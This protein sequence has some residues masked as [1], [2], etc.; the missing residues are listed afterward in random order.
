MLFSVAGRVIFLEGLYGAPL[1][2]LGVPKG[3][4]PRFR[5]NSS[6]GS[7]DLSEFKVIG[8]TS[9]SDTQAHCLPFALCRGAGLWC[10]RCDV[11]LDKRTSLSPCIEASE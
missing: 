5:P 9:H 11:H 2:T 6:M 7:T 10:F 3:K 4:C 8:I 1:Q